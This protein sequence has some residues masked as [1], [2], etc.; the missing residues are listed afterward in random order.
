MTVT[1][2]LM[3]AGVLFAVATFIGAVLAVMERQVRRADELEQF[4]RT[5]EAMRRMEQQ[6][7]DR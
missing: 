4:R 3:V 7:G 1:N 2:I 6:D 5:I